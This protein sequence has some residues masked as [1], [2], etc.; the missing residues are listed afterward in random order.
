MMKSR[1]IRWNNAAVIHLDYANYKHDLD[2]LRAE[3]IE[4]DNE[5]LR[6]P[7]GTVLALIDLRDTVASGAVVSMFKESSAITTPYIRRHA[8]IGVTGVKRFLADKVAR[9]A[10]RPMRLFDTEK[11]A[12]DWLTLGAAV[13]SGDDN[14]IGPRATD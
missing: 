8:L 4:A 13:E 1:W 5:I 11:D 12:L 10:G 6:E 7:L 9:L 14:V 2:G 3:V